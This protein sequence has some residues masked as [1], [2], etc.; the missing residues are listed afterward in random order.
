MSLL[1]S[2]CSLPPVSHPDANRQ[3]I[4]PQV[5][6][7]TTLGQAHQ[8][9]RAQAQADPAYSGF[10]ALEDPREAFAARGLLARAAERTLDV[11]YY[12]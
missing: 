10:Y 8:Q 1:L 9:L 4:A 3:A 11:Q 7:Q 12:I 2:A 6:E 5:S